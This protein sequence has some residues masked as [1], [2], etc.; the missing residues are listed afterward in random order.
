[1]ILEAEIAALRGR[2]CAWGRTRGC[3]INRG[4]S[5][6]EIDTCEAGE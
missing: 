6:G 2:R 5:R 1:M 4:N 3:V